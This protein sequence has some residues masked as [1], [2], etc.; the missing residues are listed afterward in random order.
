MKQI[1]QNLHN[2]QTQLVEVPHPAVQP[3]KL[4]IQTAVSLISSGTERMLVEFGKAGYLEKARQQ[5]DKVKQVIDKIKTDGLMPTIEAVRSKLGQPLPLGY[6]NVGRIVDAG[7]NIKGSGFSLGDRVVSNGPHAEFVCV[8]KNLVAKIPDTVSD[9]DAV[10]T[11]IGAI[12]LQGVRLAQ[13]TLGERFV[14]IGLGLI[15]LLTVQIL[16]ANGCRVL[17]IDIDKHRCVLAN[18]FGAETVNLQNGEDHIDILKSFN[19]GLSAD[20]VIITASTKSNNPV[21]LAAQMCRK[22]GRII[23]VGMSGLELNRFDFYEKE[24]SFQVSCSYGPGRYDPE[25]EEK[26]YDYPI[27]FVRWTAQRNFETVVDLIASG[28]IDVKPLI[29]HRFRFEV[30]DKAYDLITEG[31][32]PSLA[33]VLNYENKFASQEELTKF[34]DREELQTTNT[35]QE[36]DSERKI[37]SEKLKEKHERSDDEKRGTDIEDGRTVILQSKTSNTS[38]IKIAASSPVIG[39][40]GA[41]SF[42]GQV[43]LPAIHK[44]GAKLKIIASSGGVTGTHLGKKYGFEESTTDVERIFASSEINTV[45]I[46]TRHNSHA[47]FVIKALNAG[48]HVFVEKPLCIHEKELFKILNAYNAIKTIQPDIKI[49][50]GFNRRFSAHIVKIKSLIKTVNEPKSIIMTVNAGM[51]PPDHWAQDMEIGGGRIIG[52]VCHFIDL[53]R[54]LTG[55]KIVKY[56][57][58]VMENFMRDT[59][60]INLSFA[61]GSIGSIHYFA[62]GSKAFPKEILKVFCGGKVLELNNFKVLHGFGW[63]DFKKMKLW[64]QDKGHLNEIRS[65][66]HAI[67]NGSPSPIPFEEINEVTKISLDLGS[68]SS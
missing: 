27:G 65:F 36:D 61:D 21:H 34:K 66:V 4:I 60:T 49:M 12:G 50:V 37:L 18:K 35:L 48:K 46:T 64:R 45:F 15:G 29:T 67:S 24:L 47:S 5:P 10:F 58:G 22:R 39:L 53:L 68:I 17:G 33:V 52:E 59:L 25:Y 30:A 54:F 23:L 41:G 14:V 19:L 56:D 43:L 6:S 3:G 57:K 40:I 62:N 44:T 2:G 1:L 13:P 20:G 8:Q 55:E 11:V 31:K 7:F 26:G 28:K 32:E 51:L 16:L 38:E 63:K 42:T 9:E